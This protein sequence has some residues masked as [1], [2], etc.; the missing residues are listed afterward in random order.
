MF[1]YPITPR[2]AND[3]VRSALRSVYVGLFA[4]CQDEEK[5]A[6]FLTTDEAETAGKVL[7]VEGMALLEELVEISGNW[8]PILRD[9]FRRGDPWTRERSED[10]ED[11]S[12]PGED[13]R[14][15]ADAMGVLWDTHVIL[16]GS[17]WRDQDGWPEGGVWAGLHRALKAVQVQYDRALEWKGASHA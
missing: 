16:R 13:W 1:P 14:T 11:E 6:R 2:A 4:L 9:L 17:T 10:Q 8:I 5:Q 3:A 12:L 15:V 7:T